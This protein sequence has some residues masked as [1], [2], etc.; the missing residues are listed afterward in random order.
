MSDAASFGFLGEEF[1]TWLW[2]RLETEGGDF[3]IDRGRSIGVS[4]DDY[5]AF[6]PRNDDDTQHTLRSGTPSRSAEAATG[7]KNGRRLQEAKLVIALGELQWQVVVD[8]AT[9][10][11]RSIKL[12]EDDPDCEGPADKSR[13]RAANFALVQELVEQIYREFLRVR[14]RPEY[15]K[16]DAEAQANWAATR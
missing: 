5:I 4:F 14:L 15:L 12:P 13:D 2:F 6:A 11:L 3:D 16:S 8:G 10:N 7:L 1:L 9:M